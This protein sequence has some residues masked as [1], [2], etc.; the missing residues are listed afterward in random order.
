MKAPRFRLSWHACLALT[1]LGLGDPA[2]SFGESTKTQVLPPH[3]LRKA[4][5]API[6]PQVEATAIQV[7]GGGYCYSG[8]HPNDAQAA[9][10][11]TW[12]NAPG[13]HLHFY[14]PFDLRLFVLQKDCYQFVGDPSDFGFDGATQAY[15]GAHPLPNGGW[16]YMVGGHQH[17]FAPFSPQFVVVGPWLHWRGEFDQTFWSHWPY[18][19]VFFKDL[20]PQFY[21]GGQWLKSGRPAPRLPPGYWTNK[22]LAP[23][24]PAAAQH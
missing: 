22:A 11:P 13:R 23:S 19:S 15:Y 17:A 20:Y 18:Y 2:T 8:P 6:P 3:G 24:A 16:C 14:P 12:D 1:A 10:G 9:A 4:V 7:P 21:G 5:A